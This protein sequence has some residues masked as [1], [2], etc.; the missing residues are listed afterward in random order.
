MYE[1]IIQLIERARVSFPPFGNGVSQTA[2]DNAETTLGFALPQS[3]KW[4]L[5]N[6]GG[7]QIQGDI[8]YGLDEGGMGRPDVVELAK[9]NERDGLYGQERLVFCMGNA[10]NF[11]FDTQSLE[12]DGEYEVLLHDIAGGEEIP[13][14]TSFTEFLQRRI[15]EVYRL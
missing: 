8:V 1:D 5:L 9:M 10:E 4:W 12:D 7:G 6:Y 14:A 3:Y 11:V 13:Y 15:K 2:I